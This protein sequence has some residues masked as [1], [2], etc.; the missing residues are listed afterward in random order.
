MVDRDWNHPSVVMMSI[1]NES[2]GANL[3]EAADRG[4]LRQAYRQAKQIVPG[5]RVDD[6][7]ACCDNFHVA[8]DIAD[9]HQYNAIPDYAADFDR[10][11]TDES[12]PSRWLFGPYGDADRKEQTTHALEFGN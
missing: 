8:T 3:K 4:W 9:F 7:S 1:I 11:V 12:A 6:N 5:W 2:W 10:C